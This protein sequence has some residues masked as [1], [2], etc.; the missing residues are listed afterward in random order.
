MSFD[1]NWSADY[2]TFT[3]NNQIATF[4]SGSP[5][6][7][8]ILKGL[9]LPIFFDIILPLEG[10]NVADYHHYP[11]V[12]LS[13]PFSQPFRAEITINAKYLPLPSPIYI[14]YI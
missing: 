3:N 6:H 5:Y 7:I 4:T 12:R 2:Y 13:T 1:S 14:K 10:P 8:Y 11:C 9:P